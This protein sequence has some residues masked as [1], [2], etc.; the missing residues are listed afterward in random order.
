[1]KDYNSRPGLYS[2]EGQTSSS[3]IAGMAMRESFAGQTL[4]IVSQTPAAIMGNVQTL[5]ILNVDVLLDGWG[6]CV[7]KMRKDGMRVPARN[8]IYVDLFQ[9]FFCSCPS[10]TDGKRCETSPQ[11]CIGDPCINGGACKDLLHI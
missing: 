5:L 4:M 3:A 11:R 7:K 2:R 8:A 6:K 1:M 9:D 10:G